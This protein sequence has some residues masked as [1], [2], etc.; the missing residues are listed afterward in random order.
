MPNPTHIGKPLQIIKMKYSI[1]DC[2]IIY[3]LSCQNTNDLATSLA[4]HATW[5]NPCFK[6]ENY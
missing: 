6:S 1:L 5:T 3:L 2:A 4:F